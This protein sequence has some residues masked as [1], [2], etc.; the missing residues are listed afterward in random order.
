MSQDTGLPEVVTDFRRVVRSRNIETFSGAALALRKWMMDS[1]PHRP[2]YHFTGP[3]SWINDPNGPIYYDGKYHLFYQYDPIVDGKRSARCWGHAVSTDLAHWVDWPVALWPDTE[4]DRAGVY[5]GN[6]F[7]DDDGFLCAMYTGNVAGNKEAYGIFARSTDGCLTWQKK[8]VM[9][10]GQRPNLHSPVHWDGQVWKDGEAWYQ[11]VGGATGTEEPQGVAWLWKSTD[12]EHWELQKNIAPSI[13]LGRFWE[14]P[15]LI[16]LDGKHVLMV[17]HGNPYWIGGYDRGTMIFTPDSLEPRSIDNGNYYSF[18]VNMVDDKGSGGSDRQLMHGWVTGPGSPTKDVPYWQGAHSIPRVIHVQGDR[19]VQEPIPEIKALREQ[20]YEIEKMDGVDTI[21]RE[22]RGDALE[23]IATFE[24]REAKMLGV[25][26]R[27]SEDGSEFIRV[28][29]DTETG[30]YGVDGPTLER[31]I[32]E[33]KGIKMS[34]Q[35]S[36]LEPGNSVAIH[37][38]LDRSIVEVYV[39]GSAYTARVF[40]PPDALGVGIFSEGEQASLKSLKVWKMRSM[41][42][43]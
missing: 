12:L 18:N 6:T 14:L 1:D 23:I 26:L 21:L 29:F 41:F 5:S 3:E 39:N 11:L 13:K 2:I 34:R 28:F 40:S 17:G 20:C 30:E 15:Y 8:M 27:I 10:D 24:P 25:K 19:I 31:N 7:V 37:I 32:Q 36:F 9:D 42:G 16:H 33:M 38:F 35:P 43:G 22:I 4:Y